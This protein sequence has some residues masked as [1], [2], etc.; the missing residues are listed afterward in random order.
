VG[1]YLAYPFCAQ[2]CTFCN[3]ASG[4]FSRELERSYLEALRTELARFEWSWRPATL[5]LGG[6]TPSRIEPAA[7]ESLLAAAPAYPW[8]EATLEATPGSVTPQRARLWRRLG[9]NRVSLGVQS[10]VAR[11]ISR[12]GRRHTAETVAAEVAILRAAGI[13]NFNLDRIAGLPSQTPASWRESLAWV[14][15]LEAPHVSVYMLEIDEDS[16]LGREILHRGPRYGAPDALPEEQVADLYE[17]AV[18]WLEAAGVRRYE[19]ANFAR[20]GWESRH[21][22]KYW[23]LEPYAGFG[24]DAHSF[25][26][27]LRRRNAESP[28][29]YTHLVLRGASPCVESVPARIEEERFFL[30]LRLREGFRPTPEERTC[31]APPIRRF[32]EEGLLESEGDLLRLTARGVMLSNEVFQEFVNL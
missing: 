23:R 25:D 9:I 24:A 4:V 8:V 20:P 19:I 15:R 28:A 16:R 26:G 7:L 1:V 22:L 11:E 31:F 29:E 12:T 30:G 27:R 32:L 2:K 5:Y 3:F 13:L 14:E 6:G 17:A 10:F 21:N 18:E